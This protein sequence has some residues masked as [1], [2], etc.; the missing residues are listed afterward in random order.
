MQRW[1]GRDYIRDRK[2]V[3]AHN[4]FVVDRVSFVLEHGDCV[5]QQEDNGQSRAQYLKGRS[6]AL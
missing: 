5:F 4:A 2:T 3:P 6:S 1:G